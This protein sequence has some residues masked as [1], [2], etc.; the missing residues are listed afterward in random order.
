MYGALCM[1]LRWAHTPPAAAETATRGAQA[2]RGRRSSRRLAAWI[3]G[4]SPA[5]ARKFVNLIGNAEL[6]RA[7]HERGAE[8]VLGSL[9]H[10]PWA[11]SVNYSVCTYMTPPPA[12]C[13]H[14]WTLQ[15]RLFFLMTLQT[16][17]CHVPDPTLKLLLLYIT[18]ISVNIT[19]TTIPQPGKRVVKI[20]FKN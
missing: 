7:E 5:A 15:F 16:L 1:A 6:Y 19:K 3:C 10:C 18:Q 11:R 8:M 20:R 14:E 4:A 12:T 2:T 17:W 9:Q 13:R